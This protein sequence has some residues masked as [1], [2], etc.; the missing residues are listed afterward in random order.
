M[1]RRTPQGT[2]LVKSGQQQFHVGFATLGD[3]LAL[4]GLTI[5]IDSSVASLGRHDSSSHQ[6]RQEDSL[7][8]V[9]TNTPSPR[10]LK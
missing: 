1:S 7:Q 3:R 10:W 4:N 8:G 2:R 9:M 5:D 6:K